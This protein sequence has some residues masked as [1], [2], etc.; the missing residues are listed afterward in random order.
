MKVA[1]IT[2]QHFGAR[3]DSLV[4]VDFYEAFYSGTF[5]PTL[6][7]EKITNVLVLGDTFDRRKFVNFFSLQRAKTMF[8][9]RLK[10]ENITVHMLIGNHDTYYRNTNSVNSPELLLEDYENI[11]KIDG[12]DLMKLAKAFELKSIMKNPNAKRR[13]RPKK[14]LDT[15]SS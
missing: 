4:F 13:G 5:F 11:I 2:D 10:E 7:K 9:D 8:F 12:M 14:V 15:C 6:K 3:N 1:I